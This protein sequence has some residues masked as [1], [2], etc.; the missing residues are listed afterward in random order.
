MREASSDEVTELRKENDQL[1]QIV[2]ELHL[3]NRVLKKV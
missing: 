3:Q 1:K 2:A